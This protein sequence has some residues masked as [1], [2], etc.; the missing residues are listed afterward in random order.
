[1]QTIDNVIK[2]TSPS[3]EHHLLQQELYKCHQS[4]REFLMPLNSSDFNQIS[5]ISPSGH[6]ETLQNV[7]KDTS[8]SQ[9]HQNHH[10]LS[11]S[12]QILNIAPLGHMQTIQNVIKE[13]SPSQEHQFHHQL[14]QEL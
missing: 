11:D 13:T 8:P 1:M 14:Q 12:N 3:Q 2:D 9:E 6:V 4:Q 7:I 5:I 10:Q